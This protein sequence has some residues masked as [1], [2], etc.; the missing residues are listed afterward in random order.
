MIQFD[1]KKVFSYA[2]IV[3]I[4]LITA[5]SNFVTTSKGFLI[6]G[7][8]LFTGVYFY[9]EKFI[10]PKF[11]LLV[12]IF[13]GISIL[14]AFLNNAY[15]GVTYSGY[16]L[17]LCLAYYC[18]DYVKDNFYIYFVNIIYFLTCISLVLYPIQLLNFDFM[19]NLN[20]LMGLSE[21]GAFAKA[22]SFVFTMT[23]IHYLRNCGFAW[24]PGG[25]A[26]IL[27]MTF[28]INLFNIG[29]PLTSRRN[30]VF[31]IAIV[32]T[33]STMGLLS[34]LIP[35]SLVLKDF[36]MQSRTYRQLSVV[37]I[38]M[39]FIVVA[40]L[41]TQVDFLY[42]KMVKEITELDTEMEE[43]ERASVEKNAI[44]VSRSMSVILDMRTIKKYPL[45]GLGVDF[46]TTGLSKLGYDE[47][48]MTACGTTALLMRFGFVGFLLYNFLL[49]RFADFDSYLHKTAWLLL[50]NYAL[51]TQEISATPYFHLFIF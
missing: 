30:I 31:F 25:F 49:F 47:N 51:F 33:Q 27:T 43:V 28:F 17:T 10:R 34:M 12:G 5:G 50:I 26:T 14:Y 48:L 8:V 16:F 20:N 13:V 38:P 4:L 44:A 15:N 42:A 9:T 6:G 2:I 22:N 11:F 23:P 19:Y 21:V 29:E 45:F 46:R 18:R 35:L 40:S 32:T 37:I 7:W 1:A 24:E 41:F 3:F 36:I 39:V